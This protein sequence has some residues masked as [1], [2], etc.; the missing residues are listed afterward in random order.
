M[1]AAREYYTYATMA[2]GAPA[3]PVIART[4]EGFKAFEANASQPEAIKHLREGF[5]F[6]RQSLEALDP[7]ALAGTHTIF[8]R[9]HTVVEMSFD[10][11]D[12]LHEHLGQLIAYARM[13]G[14]VPPW[15]K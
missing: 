1:H 3:S 14:I 11:T 2:Y 10:V 8:G 13:N 15:S 6:A 5:A 9:P 4:Q 7:D 12:D